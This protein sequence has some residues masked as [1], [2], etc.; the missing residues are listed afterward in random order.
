MYIEHNIDSHEFS[1]IFHNDVLRFMSHGK[2]CAVRKFRALSLRFNDA[3][4]HFR[5][6]MRHKPANN[7]IYIEMGMCL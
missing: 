3:M 2:L 6:D 1:T 4:T 5:A 7:S